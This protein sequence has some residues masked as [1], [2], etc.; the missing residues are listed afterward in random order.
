MV[1]QEDLEGR[2]LVIMR[3]SGSGI[4]SLT[5]L[6]VSDATGGSPCMLYAEGLSDN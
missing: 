4:D 1:K 3:A 2:G 5:V 6:Y